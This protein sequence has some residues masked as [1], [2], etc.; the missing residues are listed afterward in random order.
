MTPVEAM[1][2][3]TPVIAYGKGGALETVRDGE[4]GIF[5]HEQTVSALNDGIERFEDMKWSAYDIRKYALKF[6]RAIF[7]KRI[8]DYISS[9]L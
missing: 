1:L 4:S 8:I 6:D 3:G 2:C 9:L 5:F 7:Q